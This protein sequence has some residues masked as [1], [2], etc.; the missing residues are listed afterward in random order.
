MDTKALSKAIRDKKK[1]RPD[2]DSAGQE[3]ADPVDAW[4]AKMSTD[5]NEA[6]DEPD[7]EP[8]SASEMG[9]N[10]SSQDIEQLKRSMARIAK[11]IESL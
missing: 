8:A 7:A 3:A 1:L 5:V 10:E 6:L 2:M 11:Y 9:E 4:D